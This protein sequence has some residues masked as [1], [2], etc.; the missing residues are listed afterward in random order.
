MLSTRQKSNIGT[1]GGHKIKTES[2][3]ITL[4]E[5]TEHLMSS[6]ITE[7]AEHPVKLNLVTPIVTDPT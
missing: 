4:E 3:N 5:V 6:S 1:L 7:E 2:P